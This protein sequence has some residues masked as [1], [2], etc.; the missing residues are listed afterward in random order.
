MD[1]KL[2]SYAKALLVSCILSEG[3]IFEAEDCFALTIHS[4][5]CF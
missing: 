3:D 2:V 5:S 4:F 1:C